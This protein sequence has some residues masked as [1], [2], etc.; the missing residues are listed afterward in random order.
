MTDP[1]RAEHLW[2]ALSACASLDR[3]ITIATVT[4]WLEHHGAGSP[5]VPLMQERIRDD[6]KLW[7]AAATQAEME[8]YVAAAV[9]EMERSAITNRAA[10]RLAALGFKSMTSEDRASFRNWVG[11]DDK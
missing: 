1:E 8:A 3:D 11:S 5:D 10:K 4:H 7:A 2:R 9:L 6:A